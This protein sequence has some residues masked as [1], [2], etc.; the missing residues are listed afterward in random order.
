LQIYSNLEYICKIIYNLQLKIMNNTMQTFHT[1]IATLHFSKMGSGQPLLFIPGSISDHRTWTNIQYKF[2]ENYECYN[3]S[4]RFQYPGS[5]PDGGDSSVHANTSDIAHFM[6]EK[7]LSPAIIVGHSFGGFIALNIAIQFPELVKCLV[8]EE[9]IFAPALAKNPKN[10][11]E[12]LSLMFKN[13][14]AGKSFARLGMKGIEPTFKSLAKGDTETAQ[15]TFI[16]GVTDGKKTPDT[17]DELSRIQLADNIASLAGEDPFINTIKMDDLKK[18]KCPV[19]LI[20]GTESPYAFQYINEQLKKCLSQAQ[21]ISFNTAGHWV[22]IDQAD[23]YV[24]EI[25]SFL[26][27]QHI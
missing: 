22:H 19:L 21:L 23:R 18:I 11:L 10:P 9:P 13:F 5:Y 1:D 16:D 6:N 27:Q 24:N 8:V 26:R 3:I 15:K 2:T 7:K 17:L 12:L 25:K 4:R 20:S 14:K